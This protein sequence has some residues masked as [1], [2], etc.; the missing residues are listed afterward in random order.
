MGSASLPAP[1]GLHDHHAEPFRRSVSQTFLPGLGSLVVVVVLDLAELPVVGV[2]DLLEDP[3][4]VVERK[5][6]VAHPPSARILSRNLSMP[7]SFILA[8][9]GRSGHGQ[10]RG[11]VVGARACVSCSSKIFS[12]CLPG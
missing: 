6:D 2:D 3:H 10:G 12:N 8:Q 11:H 4:V 1:D 9:S 5:A 7:S